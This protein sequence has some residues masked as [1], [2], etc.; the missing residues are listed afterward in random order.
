MLPLDPVSATSSSSLSSSP[1]ESVSQFLDTL[2]RPASL[3]N[4]NKNNEVHTFDPVQLGLIS[5]CRWTGHLSPQVYLR[6]CS[7]GVGVER[8]C[9]RGRLETQVGHFAWRFPGFRGVCLQNM[10]AADQYNAGQH[11]LLMMIA[12]GSQDRSMCM[13]TQHTSHAFSL[14][15]DV[16]TS[17]FWVCVKPN[18]LTKGPMHCLSRAWMLC[19]LTFW[20]QTGAGPH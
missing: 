12:S 17:Q 19:M 9:K 18:R 10:E 5:L 2:S 8:Q 14:M 6:T 16:G 15:Q 3:F 4:L 13:P 11:A 7:S 1:L 20:C